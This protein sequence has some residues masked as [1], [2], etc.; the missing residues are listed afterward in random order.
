M[1]Q[2][3]RLPAR[4]TADQADEV[5]AVADAI[6]TRLAKDGYHGVVGVDA[7]IDPD[8]GLTRLRN[9]C[10]NTMLT[11]LAGLADRLVGPGLL[12][13]ARQF[14]LRLAQPVAF[15]QL[16]RLLDGLLLDRRGGTGLVLNTFATVNAEARDEPFPGRLY[17]LVT[18]P[19]D[20]RLAELDA[21]V[22]ARLATLTKGPADAA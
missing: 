15:V 19:T 14:P 2:G 7:M 22:V 1:H 5:R 16:R 20:E 8:G 17:A 18:A 13:L 3:N 6:G 21:E 9:Q 11:Y 12:A 4:L 10:R